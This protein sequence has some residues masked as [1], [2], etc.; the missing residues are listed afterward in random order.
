[1]SVEEKK[2]IY[3]NALSFGVI[4]IIG[5]MVLSNLDSQSYLDFVL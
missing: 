2:D 1:V 3:L 4:C 5:I